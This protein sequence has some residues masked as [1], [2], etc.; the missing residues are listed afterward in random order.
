MVRIA[1]YLFL[2]FL[3]LAL[4]SISCRSAWAFRIDLWTDS[5][6]SDPACP[7]G[8]G[9]LAYRSDL[10]KWRK[11][12]NAVWSDF[13]SGGGG[14]DNIRV[15]DG[16]NAGTFT[17]MSDADF[18]DS[19]DINFTRAAG[20]P[21]ILTGTVRPDSVALLTD[22][23]GNYV[24]SVATTAPLS[25]GAAASEDAVISLT[26]SM[27]TNRIIGRGAA[28]VGVMQELTPDATISIT[29]GAAIG[30]VD[31]TCTG[32][33]GTTEI[34]ALDT[35][36]VTTGNYVATI[37]DGTG[38]DGTASGNAST[39]TPTLDLTEI[40]STTWG[41]GAFTTMTFDAGATDPVL[42]FSSPATMQLEGGG[43]SPILNVD[44][45]GEVRFLEEDAGGSDY[46]AFKAPATIATPRTCTFVD[47]ANPIPDSCVGNGVDDT[48]GAGSASSVEVSIAL[49]SVGM[50]FSSTVTGQAWVTTSTE[51]VCNPLGTTADG[52][53]PET[54]T[55]AAPR[56]TI[57]NRVA[58]T[59]FDLM[60]SNPYGLEGTVRFHC[61]GV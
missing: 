52:L 34:A 4:L 45:Q 60:V 38:I 22:T 37:A 27:A 33:L 58:G 16:D 29:A 6:T 44:D 11:C 21:D 46:I 1:T 31:V 2:Y 39:Y 61:I 54:I 47:S 12:E 24:R 8:Y 18:D 23:T 14:G 5:Q 10:N 50:F 42:R 51:I 53:T 59:G 56:A 49:T 55:V 57:A 7:A 17:A 3:V 35:A 13:G 26:T 40:S 15:E 48:G 32:C 19:G 30:V 9:S 25:G 41:A 36:D 28:G 43:T 20:P